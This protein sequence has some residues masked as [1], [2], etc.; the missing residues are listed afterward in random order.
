MS[1]I[2]RI[3][4]T[5]KLP[6]I[7]VLREKLSDGK[8]EVPE[9]LGSFNEK[10]S[11]DHI[12]EQLRDED[13]Y[14]FYNFLHSMEFAREQFDAPAD[15]LDRFLFKAAPQMKSA[16]YQLWKEAHQYGIDF[17]PEYEMLLAVLNRAKL[18]EQQLKVLSNGDFSALTKLGININKPLQ[19][20]SHLHENQQLMA[21]L[22]DTNLPMDTLAVH[23]N[24]AADHYNKRAKFTAQQL[25][26]IKNKLLKESK[27]TFPKWYYTIVISVLSSLEISLTSI[28]TPATITKHWLRLNK[29][30]TLP[31]TVKAFNTQ[32]KEFKEN[33]ICHNIL[34][35]TFINDELIDMGK[36]S[37]NV[38][39]TPS[40]AVE[41][42]IAH[43]KK[44]DP[45]FD[46]KKSGLVLKKQY[47][48]L[49]ENIYI[50]SLL[51]ELLE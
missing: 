33:N 23:L 29:K 16:L 13:L 21:A 7:T 47:P 26:V 6:R 19:P 50:H 51:R 22:F 32:I 40:L 34:K 12:T 25:E 24:K 14:E 38:S 28:A 27:E 10:K 35:Q 9:L 4:P 11:F 1:L 20:A 31:A 37:S 3:E 48:L 39:P 2:F 17:L 44:I 15:E 43:Q 30:E 18:V 41:K 8:R 5:K 49:S 42:W 45:D 46:F 36:F